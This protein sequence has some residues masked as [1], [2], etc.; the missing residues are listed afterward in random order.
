M[1]I[2]QTIFDIPVNSVTVVSGGTH[3]ANQ[4]K[5]WDT[6]GANKGGTWKGI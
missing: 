6:Q 4:G 5:V 2:T 1:Q 3:A